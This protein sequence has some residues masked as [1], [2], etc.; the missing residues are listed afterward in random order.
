MPREDDF[1]STVDGAAAHARQYEDDLLGSAPRVNT[2]TGG[3]PRSQG[4]PYSPPLQ[5]EFRCKGCGETFVDNEAGPEATEL[6]EH[7][8]KQDGTPCGSTLTRLEGTWHTAR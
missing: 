1:T 7:Y 4:A 5:Y 8:Q 6:I 3:K 2:L